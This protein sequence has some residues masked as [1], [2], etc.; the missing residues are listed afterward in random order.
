LS[1]VPEEFW[2]KAD[3]YNNDLGEVRIPSISAALSKQLRNFPFWRGQESFLPA[4]EKVYQEASQ[5]GLDM[6]IGEAIYSEGQSIVTRSKALA[7]ELHFG[8]TQALCSYV[9]ILILTAASSPLHANKL[10]SVS[11]EIRSKQFS[12]EPT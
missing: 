2:G 7:R 8:R 6:F 5:L 12:S 9:K 1:T 10:L 4:M 3:K 11:L